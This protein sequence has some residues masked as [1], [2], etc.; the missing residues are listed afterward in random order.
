MSGGGGGGESISLRQR[1]AD[2]TDRTLG[3][4]WPSESS[5]RRIKSTSQPSLSLSLSLF[6]VGTALVVSAR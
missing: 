5:C 3:E 1:F 4:Q 2:L 6:R